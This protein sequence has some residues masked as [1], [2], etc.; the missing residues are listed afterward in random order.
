MRVHVVI[1]H[2]TE[3]DRKITKKHLFFENSIILKA[4][5]IP[6]F[7]ASSSPLASLRLQTLHPVAEHDSPPSVASIFFRLLGS[8]TARRMRV[9][10]H[11][12]TNSTVI[13]TIDQKTET[14]R[15]AGTKK[16]PRHSREWTVTKEFRFLG[17]TNQTRLFGTTVNFTLNK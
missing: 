13:G 15:I 9:S 16:C 11:F 12:F 2:T 3:I 17:R 5:F 4:L 6:L 10:K 7:A 1:D 14:I 8:P